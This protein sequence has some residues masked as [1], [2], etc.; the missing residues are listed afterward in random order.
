MMSDAEIRLKALNM[1][2]EAYGHL[3]STTSDWL[4]VE[5]IVT[6]VVYGQTPARTAQMT[7]MTI[8]DLTGTAA[9]Q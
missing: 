2:R 7:A 6:Y 8:G 5:R 1:F 3:P 4:A 9:T